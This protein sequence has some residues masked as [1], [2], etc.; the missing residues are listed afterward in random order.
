MYL[1]SNR[2]TTTVNQTTSDLTVQVCMIEPYPCYFKSYLL[3]SEDNCD[4][5]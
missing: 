2:N 5:Q 3:I 1:N 4:K